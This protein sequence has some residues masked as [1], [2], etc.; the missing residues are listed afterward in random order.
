MP[1][2][3]S[4]SPGQVGPLPSRE[5]ERLSD[6]EEGRA[7]GHGHVLPCT[8]ATGVVFLQAGP[9]SD[10]GSGQLPPS[11]NPSE[12]LPAAGLQGTH[13]PLSR[14]EPGLSQSILESGG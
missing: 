12:E 9:M 2:H 3:H 14:P 11:E 10:T 4:P 1:A 5:S 8:E 6:T 7:S 13:M